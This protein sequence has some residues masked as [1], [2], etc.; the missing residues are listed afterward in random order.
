MSNKARIAIIIISVMILFVIGAGG[1]L[2]YWLSQNRAALK[3]SQ[4]A[5]LSFG[6]QTDDNGCWQEA[7]KREQQ[8]KDYTG[9]LHNNSFLLACLAAAANPPNFCEGVPLPGEMLDTARWMVE[10]CARP[11]MQ[12]LGKSD[13]EGLLRTRQTYCSAYYKRPKN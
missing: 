1:G 2:L 11:E 5:G 13:C 3:Q 8:I 10:R 4:S 6:K 9:S 7:L 12:S